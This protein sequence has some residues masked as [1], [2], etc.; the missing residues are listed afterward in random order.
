VHIVQGG[1]LN[2][3]RAALESRSVHFWMVPKTAD[4]G[5]ELVIYIRGIGFFATVRVVSQPRPRADWKNRYRADVDSVRLIRPPVSL[6]AIHRHVPD[7]GWA[8]Y[9]R[10]ITTPPPEVADKIR[11]LISGRRR[12]EIDLDENFVESASIDELRMIALH[13]ARRKVPA[14]AGTALYRAGSA[15][16]R[17]YVLERAKGRCEGCGAPAP[18]RGVDGQPFLE[19]HH[20]TRLADDGPDHPREVIGICPNCHKKAHLAEDAKSFNT[21]LIKKLRILEAAL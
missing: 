7:F 20:T 2:G 13:A 14:K 15:A 21:S 3:D 8:K 6:A 1:I 12:G 9:P 4:K 10:S 17:R 16:I 19:A 18:F 5:D 11:A